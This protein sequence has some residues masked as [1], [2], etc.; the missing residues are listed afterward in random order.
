MKTMTLR[1][2]RPDVARELQ[3]QASRRGTSVN[4]CVIEMVESG[5]LGDGENKPREHSD[6]DHLFGTLSEEDAR[7]IEDV[8]GESRT[9]D[10]EAWRR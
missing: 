6:L 4:R 5:V 9:I 8:L 1:G 3:R 10:V 7:C 2:L